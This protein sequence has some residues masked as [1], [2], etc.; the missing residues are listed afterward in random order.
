MRRDQV[1]QSDSLTRAV[2]TNRLTDGRGGSRMASPT[3]SH[4]LLHLIMALKTARWQEEPCILMTTDQP[5][6]DI[7]SLDL[8]S[9]SLC[10]TEGESSWSNAAAAACRCRLNSRHGAQLFTCWCHCSQP[11]QGPLPPLLCSKCLSSVDGAMCQLHGRKDGWSMR[12]MV[13]PS[14]SARG[15]HARD[16]R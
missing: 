7:I 14:P 2:P 16:D 5:D 10:F 13:T 4:S 12:I 15:K 6:T 9:C 3:G 8:S 11:T 1:S